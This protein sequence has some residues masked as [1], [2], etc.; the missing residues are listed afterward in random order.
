MHM[1]KAG[2]L[3]LVVVLLLVSALVGCTSKPDLSG[4]RVALLVDERYLHVYA[5]D[6]IVTIEK[7]GGVVVVV[8]PQTGLV[9]AMDDPVQTIVA[10]IAIGDVDP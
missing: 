2:V 10:E 7:Y 1:Q 6:T 9:T 4:K 3:A 5:K 8:A